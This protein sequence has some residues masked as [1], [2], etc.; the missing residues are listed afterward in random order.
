MAYSRI[1]RSFW[2]A[3][4][5]FS[6]N[7]ASPP[8]VHGREKPESGPCKAL[9][10]YVR[11]GCPYCELAKQF[12][13][14]FSDHYPGLTISL[15]DVQKDPVARERFADLN[16]QHGEKLPGVPSF[17]GCG[18]FI[19]GFGGA[20]TTGRELERLI[21]G[22]EPT[23]PDSPGQLLDADTPSLPNV[24][25]SRDIS[26]ESPKSDP[27]SQAVTLPLFGKV[28]ALSIGLPLFTLAVG[29]VD[30]FNPCAMWVLLFLLS[31]LVNVGSRWR[32]ALIAGVFVT[33]SGL[34]YFAFMA[35]WLNVFLLV[36]FSRA[37]QVS[38]GSIAVLIAAVHIKDF[39][40]LHKGI[41]LSIP[42]SAK[43]GIYRRVRDIIQ[44]NN[45]WAALAGVTVLAV[46]LNTVELL[47][48]AGL[49]AVYTHVL[50]S[51]PLPEWERYGYLALYNIAYMADDALMAT[52]AVVTF[53]R[54]R[55]EERE[56]RWLKL[57]SGVVIGLLGLLLLLRPGWLHPG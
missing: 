39:F 38:L 20:R 14:T 4:A 28:N 8:V 6:L 53:S 5:L 50:A 48:T 9:E 27:Q 3:A 40:A 51:Y 56:G 42:E 54:R 35:A 17:Y 12:L 16:R 45:L 49:P 18:R 1:A 24:P 46:L 34:A 47:C 37:V 25:A 33:I 19:V 7:F 30:G 55:L 13:Q 29:L 44:A 57:V 10:V 2:C 22:P 41:S 36:G 21:S 11:E 43:P 32:M 31:L 26:L 23:G 52:I 15:Y